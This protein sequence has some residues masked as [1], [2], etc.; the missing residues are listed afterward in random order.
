MYVLR[1]CLLVEEL[2]QESLLEIG[3]KAVDLALKLGADEAEAYL[4]Y[5][6]ENTVKIERNQI[7]RGLHKVDQGIG[8]RIAYNKA[9]GFSYTNIFDEQAIRKTVETA[10]KSAKSSKPDE[11]WPGFPSA[12]RFGN[13][14]KVFD[15][16][17]VD[18]SVEELSSQASLMLDAALGYDK[19]VFVTDGEMDALF[20]I[21]AIVNSNGIEVA[22]KG[23]AISCYAATL[24]RENSKVTPI[25]FDYDV[26][27]SYEINPEKV[28][29]NASKMAV[30]ALKAKKI[31]TGNYS[32]VFTEVSLYLLLYYTLITA[33]KA[34]AVQ[35]E[36]SAL[37]GKIGQKVASEVLTIY[38]DGL[39]EGGLF[40]SRFDGEGVP[41]QKTV[42]I[43][44]GML[45][46]YLYDCY[47]ASKDKV[48]STGNARR[49]LLTAYL[50]TPRLEATNFVIEK[51]TK[52]NEELL[53]EIENGVLIGYLQGAHSSNPASGEFSVVATPAWKIENGEIAYS[54]KGAM[55]AGNIYD[56]LLNVSAVG[57]EYRQM[58]HLVSP[59]VRTENLKV[60][61]Q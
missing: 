30:S 46:N 7:I 1:R 32:A 15:S 37:K 43:E 2:N 26:S 8:V 33:I 57:R 17:I 9:L 53:N 47:T 31:E 60:V 48:E 36:Q 61:G 39:F 12:K 16:R 54:I 44:N 42:L 20:L 5:G 10:L 29:L 49:G 34:D 40:T 25:C 55:L 51:G 24:A 41:T 28:G 14:R 3:K 56:L 35:R 50:S 21:H 38:D 27:R 6:F 22:G 58:D 11:N 59:W 23:T 13:P 18:L 45:R 52:S 4:S 19:Q